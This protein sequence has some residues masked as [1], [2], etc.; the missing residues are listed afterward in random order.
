MSK[1][2]G[3]ENKYK[4]L[5]PNYLQYPVIT[6]VKPN[7]TGKMGGGMMM[8]YKTGSKDVVKGKK[9]VADIDDKVIAALNTAKGALS[10]LKDDASLGIKG[11]KK[12]KMNA[13]AKRLTK[14]E[15]SFSKGNAVKLSPKQKVIA[16]KAPPMNRIDGKDFAVLKDE[17]AKGRGQG[18][19]DE[20]MKPGK[21]YKA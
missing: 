7:V 1:K 14:T 2:L 20:K 5:K 19:Q 8:K 12:I 15:G 16:A 10:Y 3:L 21:S 6:S 9:F 11:L 17:K 18:L 13:K 4:A